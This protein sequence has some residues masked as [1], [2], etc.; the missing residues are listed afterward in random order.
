M[1]PTESIPSKRYQHKTSKRT[2]SIYGAHPA[3]G[4]LG[5]SYNDWE[6][7]TVGWTTRNDNGTVGTGRTP[8]ATKEA[9]D[10]FIKDWNK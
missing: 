8:F 5:D 3:S 7:V 4:A 10:Q 2:A 6:V 1:K 9:C